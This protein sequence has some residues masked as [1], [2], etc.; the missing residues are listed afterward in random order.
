V[1]VRPHDFCPFSEINTVT[2]HYISRR[3]L[4][5][6]MLA[7]FLMPVG[8]DAE[9]YSYE[10]SS[11][12][13]HFV[14]DQ[15]NIPKEYRQKRQVRKDKYDDLPKEERAL[16]LG[17]DSRERE[18]A[19]HSEAYQ[20]EQSRLARSEKERQEALELQR[21]ALTTPVV[22]SGRQVFVPVKLLNGSS[23]TEAM[24]LLDT[25]ASTSVITPEVAARLNIEQSDTVMVKVVGGRVLKVKRAVLRQ[26][27]VGPVQRAD[28][29]VMIISQR[30]GGFGDGLLGMDF[31][32]GLKYTIDFQSQTINW[33]P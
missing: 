3:L 19:R 23:V 24:L 32:A 15:G 18:A 14:D 22:I 9:F 20:Q 13:I 26:M 31:L 30:G 27:E 16:M 33:I 10:D 17:K 12:T 5:F 11:G 8:A 25:G 1:Q 2:L 28:Q 4:S 29:Q 21:M 6:G 7:A